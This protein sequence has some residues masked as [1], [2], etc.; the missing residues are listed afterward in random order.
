MPMLS[1]GAN[2]VHHQPFVNLVVTNVRGPEHPLELLGA[3]LTEIVP[4]VPLAGNLTLGVAAFSY[5]GRLAI[6]LHADAESMG[7]LDVLASGIEHALERL[8]PEQPAS[9]TSRLSVVQ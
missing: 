1:R 9:Q 6:G 8:A 5:R 2:L 7:D 3:E 4:I